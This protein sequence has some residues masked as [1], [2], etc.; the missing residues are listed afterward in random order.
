MC[1]LVNELENLGRSCANKRGLYPGCMQFYSLPDLFISLIKKP[2]LVGN[3]NLPLQV[4]T[5]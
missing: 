2:K 1:V 4:K 3:K 5:L